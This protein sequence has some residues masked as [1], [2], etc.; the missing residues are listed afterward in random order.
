MNLAIVARGRVE[1]PQAVL[2]LVDDLAKRY[3]VTLQLLDADAVYN[4]RHLN[5]AIAHAERAFQQG[6]NAAKTLG[7]EILLYASGER[8]VSRAIERVGIRPGL[9]RVVILAHGARA[10]A[11]TWGL[12][13]RLGWTKDPA[14]LQTNPNAL[15]RFGITTPPDKGEYALLERVALVDLQK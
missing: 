8:Q 15:S 10:G 6:R 11:A 1:D 13:D 7:A 12:L 9:E 3:D 2:R 14:G 4:E 5:S